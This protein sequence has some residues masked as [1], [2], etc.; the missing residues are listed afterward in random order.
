ML[1]SLGP[2]GSPKL[3]PPLLPQGRASPGQVVFSGPSPR[4]P[5]RRGQWKGKGMGERRGKRERRVGLWQSVAGGS[6][7]EN[8]QHP[9]PGPSCGHKPAFPVGSQ[10]GPTVATRRDAP[11]PSGG[12]RVGLGEVPLPTDVPGALQ[13]RG[14]CPQQVQKPR[15]CWS[16]MGR[17]GTHYCGNRGSCQAGQGASEDFWLGLLWGSPGGLVFTW[18]SQD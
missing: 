7:P 11:S 9:N 1:Q 14:S 8:L 18:V 5:L 6:P 12:G 3:Q 16:G 15:G 10:A 13:D 17:G 2:R 4:A